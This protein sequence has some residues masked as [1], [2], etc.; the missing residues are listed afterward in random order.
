MLPSE[1]ASLG[2]VPMMEPEG[3]MIGKAFDEL[4]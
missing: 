3:S 1:R 4:Y 2:G